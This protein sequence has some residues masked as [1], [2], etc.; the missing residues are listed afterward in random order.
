MSL[1]APHRRIKIGREV[2]DLYADH[3]AWN[4][5][6]LKTKRSYRHWIRRLLR[7]KTTYKM[8]PLY[9]FLWAFSARHRSSQNVSL[10]LTADDNILKSHYPSEFLDLI[11]PSQDGT[12]AL[13]QIILEMLSECGLVTLH[14]EAEDEGPAQPGTAENPPTPAL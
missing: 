10:P 9:L 1:E 13:R 5:M 8:E 3:R 7:S 14:Y 4:L 11:D 12:V 6:E 2:W